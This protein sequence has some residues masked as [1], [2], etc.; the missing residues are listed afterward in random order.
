[1]SK[2]EIFERCLI[3]YRVEIL[4]SM[5]FAAV[6]NAVLRF[7]GSWEYFCGAIITQFLFWQGV[8]SY[9]YGQTISTIGGAISEHDSKRA[10]LWLC[11]A[12]FFGYLAVFMFDGAPWNS[13]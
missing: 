9:L 2:V 8:R 10:R 1:M 12:M 7:W 3:K 11:V 13:Y 5:V 6:L 4:C